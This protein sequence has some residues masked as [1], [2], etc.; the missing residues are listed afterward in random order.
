MTEWV[1]VGEV[2]GRAEPVALEHLRRGGSRASVCR[3]S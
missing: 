1:A 3:P 2:A